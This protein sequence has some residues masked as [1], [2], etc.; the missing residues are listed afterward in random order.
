MGAPFAQWDKK[1]RKE[2]TV[3]SDTLKPNRVAVALVL[4]TL[5]SVIAIAQANNGDYGVFVFFLVLIVFAVPTVVLSML[6]SLALGRLRSKGSGTVMTLSIASAMPPLV[7]LVVF[8]EAGQRGIPD[9]LAQVAP[10]LIASCV[11][12]VFAGVDQS[13][14]RESVI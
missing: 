2:V 4:M 3:F 5:A 1:G 6:H 14:E 8:S 7:L 9:G 10:Y 13:S 11:H 12:G